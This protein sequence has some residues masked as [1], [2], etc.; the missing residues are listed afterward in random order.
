MTVEGIGK[1]F[2]VAGEVDLLADPPKPAQTVAFIAPFDPLVWDRKLVQTL[3]GFHYAWELFL[4]PAKRRWGWYTLPILYGDRLVGRFDP[5]IERE[6]NAVEVAGAWWEDG[7]DPDQRAFKTA[8]REA[9]DAYL[10]F[11]GVTKLD[12]DYM[13]IAW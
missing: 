2:V 5:R 1:K 12:W 13:P 4:P 3:F 7:F 8:M 9:L 11:A 6:R 10:K